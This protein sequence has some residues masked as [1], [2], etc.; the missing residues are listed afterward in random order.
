MDRRAQMGSQQCPVVNQTVNPADDEEEWLYS[1]RPSFQTCVG[2]AY[3]VSAARGHRAQMGWQQC[4]VANQL[5]I[6]RMKKIEWLYSERNQLGMIV[7]CARLSPS[8]PRQVFCE[9][10]KLERLGWKRARREVTKR[11]RRRASVRPGRGGS[12]YHVHVQHCYTDHT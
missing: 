2:K 6:P 7:N 10:T 11:S 3:S 8:P 5:P 4:P 1:E 12:R 9:A